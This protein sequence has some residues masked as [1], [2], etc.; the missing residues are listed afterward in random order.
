VRGLAGAVERLIGRPLGP[1]E[2]LAVAASGGPDSLALL[3]MAREAY[4]HRVRALT[5]DHGLRPEAAAEAAR[6]AATCAALGA[7]HATLRWEGPKPDGNLQAAAR[8]ARYRLMG[9]W[10]RAN[11]VAW[12][13]TAHHADDR[14]ETLL[15]RLARGAGLAG[16]AGVRPARPLGD[17]VTLLRPLLEARRH[18]LAAVVAASGIEAVDDPSNRDGRFDRTRIRALLAA[19]EDLDA[20]R[21]AASAS[22]LA[23]AEEALAWATDLAWRSRVEACGTGLAVDAAGLPRELQRRL[24]GRVVGALAAGADPRGADVDRLL[25]RLAGGGGGTL[26]GVKGVGGAVWRFGSA[27]PRRSDA[28][29]R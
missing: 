19:N 4:G 1:Q 8:E 5:V 23:D 26:A 25:D 14:A 16:L 21:V 24:I 17:G 20:G 12:L 3:L 10:C 27:P 13:A 15:L 6:V 9:E 2:P 11:D 22:H 28:A 18:D 29:A 7:A